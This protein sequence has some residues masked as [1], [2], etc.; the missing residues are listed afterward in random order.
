MVIERWGP[1]ALRAQRPSKA[2][3][4]MERYMDEI[5]AGW[6]FRTW[7]RLPAEELCWS[8]P[9]EMYEKDEKFVIRIEL[10]GVNSDEIDISLKGDTL[11]IKG[12]RK[13]SE[14]IKDEE[15]HRAELAYGSFSRSITL[16]VEVDANGIDA[17][18]EN[19]ILEVAVPKAKEAKA[20]KVQIKTKVV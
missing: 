6:P 4:E 16:P 17:T 15:Y 12:E 2:L 8:P 13:I 20:S 9:I 3:D 10:P 18:Y 11:I 7:R 1:S 19:G 14:G 5:L